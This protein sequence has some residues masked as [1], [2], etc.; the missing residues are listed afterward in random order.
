MYK[1]LICE[2]VKYKETL[3]L[4]KLRVQLLQDFN[5]L[6]W[7]IHIINEIKACNEFVDLSLPLNSTQPSCYRRLTASFPSLSSLTIYKGL[8]EWS[9]ERTLKIF[10]DSTNLESVLIKNYGQHSHK[11]YWYQQRFIRKELERIC[12]PSLSCGIFEK[13]QLRRSCRIGKRTSTQKYLGRDES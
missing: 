10:P 2:V 3:Q 4:F 6:R 13:A 8:R 5:S 11:H 1:N 7:D 9:P 12:F